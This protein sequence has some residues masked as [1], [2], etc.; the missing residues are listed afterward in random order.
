MGVIQL[1]HYNDGKEKT[2]SHCVQVF[3]ESVYDI[4]QKFKDADIWNWNLGDLIAHG[5][6]EEEAYDNFI[7]K[8]KVY[9]EE[10]QKLAKTI[11]ETDI[12]KNSMKKVD[13]FGK[14]IKR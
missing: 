11:L 7:E 10:M 12:L 3:D 6:T 9:Y 1:G 14:E 5:Y 13:C 8:F 2:N 4:P